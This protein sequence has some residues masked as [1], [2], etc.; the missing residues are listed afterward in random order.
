[1]TTNQDFQVM[2]GEVQENSYGLLDKLRELQAMIDNVRDQ[3]KR[4][5]EAEELERLVD[6]GITAVEWIAEGMPTVEMED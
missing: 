2:L 5:E 6:E 4:E 3:L 1:M